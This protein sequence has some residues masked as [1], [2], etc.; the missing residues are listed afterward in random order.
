MA[1]NSYAELKEFKGKISALCAS[2]TQC[3]DDFGKIYHQYTFGGVENLQNLIGKLGQTNFKVIVIGKFS[4]GKSSLIN[5]LLGEMV[6]PDSLSPCT[7]YINEI[8]Y[9]EEKQATIYFKHPLPEHWQD[10]V[11]NDGVKEHILKFVHSSAGIVDEMSTPSAGTVIEPYVIP[12]EELEDCVTIPWDE[13]DEDVL[14]NPQNFNISPFEKAVIQYPCELCRNGIEIIDS[15][16]LDESQD[17]TEIVDQ[18]LNKVD[19]V[20]Y[21]MTN[22]ATGGDSD[23]EIIEKYLSDNDIKNVFFVC[24]LFGIPLAKAQKQL[25]GRL[26][27]VFGPKTLLGDNGIHLVNIRDPR[28][29]GVAEFE[30]ALAEYLNK[31]K[32]K[33]QLTA[34]IEQLS[35]LTTALR[36][37]AADFDCVNDVNLVNI[38]GE[39][40]TLKKLISDDSKLL[41]DSKAKIAEMKEILD[42]YGKREVP[43]KFKKLNYAIRI[44]IRDRDVATCE[45]ANEAG[46][47]EAKALA[48]ALAKEYTE[49]QEA[50]FREVV[51]KE[52]T[53][54]VRAEIAEEI[55]ALQALVD[56]FVANIKG[57]NLVGTE[58]DFGAVSALTATIKAELAKEL[59]ENLAKFMSLGA[60]KLD[61]VIDNL[62]KD[63]FFIYSTFESANK[64]AKLTSE[65][66]NKTSLEVYQ[67]LEKVKRVTM[68]DTMQ[69]MVKALEAIAFG[70]VVSA[71]ELAVS[72]QEAKLAEK[73][74]QRL[75]ILENQA[76]E[77]EKSKEV[78]RELNDNLVKLAVL[79][80]QVNA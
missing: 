67:K 68:E 53:E 79:Q 77:H 10:F 51:Y 32:G 73:E 13:D 27:K 64:G 9:G 60:L 46:E 72:E 69:E 38:D 75:V 50:D 14:E 20:I 54:E 35:K 70:K 16:G 49:R 45:L 19:A 76:R 43:E 34:Y 12:L 62:V 17:R 2:T 22:I 61:A 55:E 29:T 65:V 58:A 40:A 6:L 74:A 71:M 33:A 39:I 31:E 78:L 57:Q 63:I 44:D 28:N 23:K 1:V 21:V 41:E 47:A 48:Q 66:L 80:M 7:A 37:G 52:I 30:A 8:V 11:Q 36:D 15:P 42:A 3:I 26:K 59:H 56:E 4:T 5:T 24:N 18:Y 25:F